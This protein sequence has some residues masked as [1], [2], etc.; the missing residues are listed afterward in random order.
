MK[1]YLIKT[2][3]DREDIEVGKCF[4]PGGVDI[5]RPINYNDKK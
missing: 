1:T 2:E 3:T 5:P 4:L